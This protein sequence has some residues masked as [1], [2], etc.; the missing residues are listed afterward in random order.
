[1]LNAVKLA[2]LLISAFRFRPRLPHS[3]RRAH[4]DP[5][6]DADS[7]SNSDTYSYSNTDS[8]P[9]T[10]ADSNSDSRLCSTDS[11]T[12]QRRWDKCLQRE[13]RRR[14]GKIH[15]DPGR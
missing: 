15:V 2:I 13:A 3:S 4:S 14:S 5:N 1:M 7:Y 11:A 8:D 10:D 6:T 9:Y 12:D